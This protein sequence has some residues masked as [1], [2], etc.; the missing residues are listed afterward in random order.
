M[1]QN[2][3]AVVIMIGI[4]G[5]PAGETKLHPTQFLYQL[6]PVRRDGDCAYDRTATRFN[7][8]GQASNIQCLKHQIFLHFFGFSAHARARRWVVE[9]PSDFDHQTKTNETSPF[10]SPSKSTTTL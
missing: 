9:W 4:F 6:D 1:T 10:A 3:G 2:N 7:L 5:H 8:V